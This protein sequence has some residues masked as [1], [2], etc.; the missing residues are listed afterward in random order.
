MVDLL[1]HERFVAKDGRVIRVRE[2]GPGDA[3][4]L[5]EIFKHMSGES[6]Y[7]RY[8]QPMEK[9][10]PV[11]VWKEAI[12]IAY[13]D[14]DREYGL[15]AFAD[16]ADGKEIPIGAARLVKTGE[17]TAEVAISLRDDFQNLGIGTKMM[18]RLAFDA[19]DLGYRMLTASIR[20]DNPA[21]WRVFNSLPFAVKR[22]VEGNFSELTIDLSQER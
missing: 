7:Q 17:G 18:R 3:T 2:I 15:I 4:L 11:R 1:E 13:E 21:I 22:V 5:V 8:N 9:V 16:G 10:E 12:H 6:R 19:R 20:N 14:R